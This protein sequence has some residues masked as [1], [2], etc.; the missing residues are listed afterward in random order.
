MN[1]PREPFIFVRHGRTDW[2]LEQLTLGPAD[3]PLNSVGE[4]QA[5]NAANKLK[6]REEEHVIVSSPLCRAAQTAEI[7]AKEL[8]LSVT[9]FPNLHERYYGD[10]RGN[11][12]EIFCATTTLPF[13]AETQ[14]SFQ[15]RVERVFVAILK[16]NEVQEKKVIVSHGQ[17]FKYLSLL[18]ANQEMV[19]DY[20]DLFLFTPPLKNE[21]HWDVV[22][23]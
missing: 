14:E 8:K 16:V 10:F 13:D 19:C 4:K 17:V 12:T 15:T 21:N 23:L 20:G 1:I 22:K 11:A 7:I 5:L 3:L 2:S 18:L 9:S 6:Q